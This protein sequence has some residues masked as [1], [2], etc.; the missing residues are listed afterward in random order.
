MS[1]I[2]NWTVDC[3]V[4]RDIST[5]IYPV[6]FRHLDGIFRIKVVSDARNAVYNLNT[7]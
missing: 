6:I 7:K 4:G 1:I 3:I 2:I 5:D